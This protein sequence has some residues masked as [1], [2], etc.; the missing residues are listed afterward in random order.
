MGTYWGIK[1]PCNE[2]G[3]AAPPFLIR[4][5]GAPSKFGEGSTTNGKVIM[6]L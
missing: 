3:D 6:K 2:V 1:G 5:R 4:G